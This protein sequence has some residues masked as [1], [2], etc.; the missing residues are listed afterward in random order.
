MTLKKQ[1][2]LK[3]QAGSSS[4]PTAVPLNT[5]LPSIIGVA[6]SGNTL[7][8]AVGSWIG[9]PTSFTYQWAA[10]NANIPGATS[11]TFLLTDTQV[12]AT[13]TVTV[14]ATN[15]IGPSAPAT[16]A[17]TGVVQPTIPFNTAIPVISGTAQSGQTL[18]T[19]N[20]TWL[21]APTSYTYQWSANGTAI[22][23]ATSSTFLLT[24]TQV[25]TAITVSVTAINPAGSSIPA[26]SASVGPVTP[27]GGS[28]GGMVMPNLLV[29]LT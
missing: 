15:I 1:T 7:T 28:D 25:G 12:G 24:D 13:I 9:S 6:R 27:R 20:G 5:I 10:N 21:H 4:V 23:G 22:P 16:S 18:S 2:T 17:P 19:T 11:S 29:A 8:A 3:K 26:R 14:I